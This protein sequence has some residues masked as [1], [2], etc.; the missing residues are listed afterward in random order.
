MIRVSM[1]VNGKATAAHVD[2][3]TLLVQY[4][5]ENL[6]LTGTHVGCDTSQCGACVVHVD[7]RA[8]K[9]CTALAVACEGARV[10]TIEGLAEGGKLHPMQQAFQD[11]H[12]LQCGFCTPGMIMTAVDMVNH[13]GSDLDEATIRSEL[14]G[15]ICRCTGYHNIVKSVMQGAHDMGAQ[16]QP[17]AAE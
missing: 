4:L 1:T 5:R 8:I 13:K 16:S 6:R 15:N 3:R 2:S 14:E 9:S 7:G 17:K 10:L 11:N 12:G